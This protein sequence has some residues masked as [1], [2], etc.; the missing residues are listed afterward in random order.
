MNYIKPFTQIYTG[1]LRKKKVKNQ[2][3]HI[4]YPCTFN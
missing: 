2:A 3:I 4:D 1:I